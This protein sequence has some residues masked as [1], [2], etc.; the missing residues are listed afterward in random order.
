V[1]ETNG[2]LREKETKT[3]AGRR[4]ALDRDTLDVLDA[5][6]RHNE[7]RA[8][9]IGTHLAGGAYVFSD[10]PD[11]A[12]PWRPNRV[13]LAFV[14]L[15]REAGIKDVR[16]HDLRHFAATQMLAGGIPVNTVAGRLGHANPATTLNVYAHFLE[17]SDEVAA[18]V[19]GSLLGANGAMK[20]DAT[21][22][23]RRRVNRE[24]SLE[25][26]TSSDE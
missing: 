15:C 11:G 25:G 7:E 1:G 9:T 23:L 18:N 6:N 17:S 5:H 26:L 8:Q 21:R 14:R 20:G 19:L 16:L 3:H 2:E 22:R 24:P 12:T 13:T 10:A 4:I